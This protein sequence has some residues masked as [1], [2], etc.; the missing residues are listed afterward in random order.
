MHMG[1]DQLDDRRGRPGVYRCV[2]CGEVSSGLTAEAE[3][4]QF[5]AKLMT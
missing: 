1:N 5:V 3:A 4:G 2:L